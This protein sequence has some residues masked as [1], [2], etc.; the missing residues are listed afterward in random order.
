M[1]SWFMEVGPSLHPALRVSD[2]YVYILV[3]Y[4]LFF[5]YYVCIGAVSLQDSLATASEVEAARALG[6]SYPVPSMQ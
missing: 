4:I 3:Y 6:L 5:S 2:I 1:I